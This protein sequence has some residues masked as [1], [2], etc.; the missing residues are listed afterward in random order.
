LALDHAIGDGSRWE[1][2]EDLAADRPL[3]DQRIALGE[4]LWR[5]VYGLGILRHS[6][7]PQHMMPAWHRRYERLIAQ[8]R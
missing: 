3:I 8:R 1:K 6:F 4:R 2:E 5:D 7:N